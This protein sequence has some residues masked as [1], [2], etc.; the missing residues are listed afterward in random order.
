MNNKLFWD[1]AI[2]CH[3]MSSIHS[4]NAVFLWGIHLVVVLEMNYHLVYNKQDSYICDG[5]DASNPDHV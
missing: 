4:V 5:D 3:V 1:N 2:L